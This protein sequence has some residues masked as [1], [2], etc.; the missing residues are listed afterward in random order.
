VQSVNNQRA[1]TAGAKAAEDTSRNFFR[2]A[3]AYAYNSL[4]QGVQKA[5]QAGASVAGAAAAGVEGGVTDM[6]NLSTR[7]RSAMVEQRSKDVLRMQASDT[8]RR[9]GDIMSQTIQGLDT[10]LIVDSLD[11]TTDV[12]NQKGK[13][14]FLSAA[15][16]GAA[17]T[18]GGA[19]GWGNNAT[20]SSIGDWAKGLFADKKSGVDQ[21]LGSKAFTSTDWSTPSTAPSTYGNSNTN[22]FS[23][24]PSESWRSWGIGTSR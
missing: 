14:S 22:S 5:E 12:A 4:S 17:S 3:D 9:A 21:L 18:F 23:F 8:E 2:T 11:Y 16:G 6:V 24:A 20:F 7:L 19:G 10:S 13:Q 15:V 1:L